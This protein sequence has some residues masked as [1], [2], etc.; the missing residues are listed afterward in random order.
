MGLKVLVIGSG[1][2][3]HAL[4]WTL[5]SSKKVERIFC[6]PG[7]AAISQ[8]AKCVNL[9]SENIRG[10]SDF[11]FRNK[12]NLTVVGPEKCLA[13]GI[14]DEFQRR[15]L[16]IFGPDRK[17]AQLE[18]SKVF[19]KDFMQRHHIP[20]APYR[21]FSTFAEAI[22]FCKTVEYPIVIKADGLAAGKGVIIVKN[23]DDASAVID[24]IMEKRIF[25]QA[26]TKIVIET[27][28]VGEEVSV[29][30]VTDGISILS[31]LPSQDHKRALD[32]DRGPNTGGMGAYC[33]TPYITPDITEQIYE[34]ILLPVLTGL[35]KDNLEYTG[36]LYAG[37]MLTE[38]GPRVLEF[39]VRFGDPETQVV[40]P[41]LKTD[42][43]DLIIA[44]MD[45]KL[46]SFSPEWCPGSAA[47]VVMASR[48]YPGKYPTG[49]RITGL[50]GQASADSFVLHAGTRRD[51]N[52]WLTD[53]GR[54]LSVVGT[55]S[56]LKAALARAYDVVR[57]I[58]FDGAMFRK[59]IGLRA[60]SAPPP[61]LAVPRPIEL[62]EQ[63]QD[64]DEAPQT[65]LE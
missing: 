56:D 54:V 51:N 8:H 65:A 60:L 5:K 32:G 12:I 47:C 15:K 17:A 33:P 11:A 19:A 24:D 23:F 20:T 40:L 64:I 25:G 22:G 59:D 7:N 37:L 38:S 30:A 50:P 42:L 16:K 1:A 31:L 57:R 46:Q 53:G 62:I 13:M 28:L 55:G 63:D 41:L 10:L 44:C 34:H 21:V 45:K 43:V 35:R 27:C 4:V 48:G 58:R 49:K 3:E 52:V 29:M 61:P 36:V 18:S 6:A 2:R 14:V 39:N 9:K 26:G